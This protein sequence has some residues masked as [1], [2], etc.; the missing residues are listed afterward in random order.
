MLS[1]ILFTILVFLAENI[2]QNRVAND[3]QLQQQFELD[4]DVSHP[5]GPTKTGEKQ[6]RTSSK[7]AELSRNNSGAISEHDRT[8]IDAQP[9]R[10]HGGSGSTPSSSF[11]GSGS[12]PASATLN[13]SDI[14]ASIDDLNTKIVVADDEKKAEAASSGNAATVIGREQI[15]KNSSKRI[16]TAGGESENDVDEKNLAGTINR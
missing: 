10:S 16:E 1:K 13:P 4:G 15:G 8:R 11:S 6:T 14:A 3:E 12:T 7:T 5:S 2:A 9:Q